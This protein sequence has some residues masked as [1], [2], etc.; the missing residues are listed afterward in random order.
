MTGSVMTGSVMKRRVAILISGRGSN[1]SALIRAAA[2]A[3][4][5][6]EISLVISNKADA[7]GL[8]R[9]RASGMNTQVIESKPF[10]KDRAGFEKV[11]QAA[12]DGLGLCYVPE[13]LMRPHV[14]AGHL[15]PVL[16]D[17]WPRVDGYHL[18]FASRRQ[19]SPAFSL[20]LEALRH[21]VA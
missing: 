18:Y 2:V 17:W 7:V 15:V 1:M 11:L 8:E 5:P 20:V 9:A 21:R 10:G 12:L 14:D 3:D 4:F 13:D 16:E 19:M 6:A